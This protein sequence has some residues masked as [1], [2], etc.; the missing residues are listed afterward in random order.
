M[1]EAHGLRVEYATWFKRPTE[2]MNGEQGLSD[3]IGMFVR[4]AFKIVD[5]PT[6]QAI[7]KEAEEECRPKLY[8]DGK[9]YVDYTRIRMK[10]VKK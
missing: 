3:W 9:W 2:Q 5:A 7:I 1:V 6:A 10:A 4:E 8:R